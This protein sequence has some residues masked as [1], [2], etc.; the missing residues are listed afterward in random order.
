VVAV[1]PTPEL[2]KAGQQIHADVPIDWVDDGLPELNRLLEREGRFDLILLTAVWMHLDAAERRTAMAR[3]ARLLA[4]SGTIIMS[5]RHGPV[6]EGRRMF[7]VSAEETAALG[8]I[9][10][11]ECIFSGER[12][13]MLGRADVGWSLL[14][15][16][17]G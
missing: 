13:D 4:P 3:L 1:E 11:L 5:L 7:D 6:P 2:R 9:S 10:G 8:R 16:R 12:D 17:A 15:L 14:A